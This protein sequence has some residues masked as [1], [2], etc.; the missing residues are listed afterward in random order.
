MKGTHD[1]WYY[2]S[3]GGI[4]RA[5]KLYKKENPDVVNDEVHTSFPQMQK[6]AS[7]TLQADD[8]PDVAMCNRGPVLLAISHRKVFWLT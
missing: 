1:F 7:L 3:G 6:N 2:S 5:I 8:A 4:E